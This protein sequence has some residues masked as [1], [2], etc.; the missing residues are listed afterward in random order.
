MQGEETS[1][2][3]TC[4]VGRS[5]PPTRAAAGRQPHGCER[6]PGS[7]PQWSES[8]CDHCIF[9]AA[10]GGGAC[11]HER[12][13][14]VP[15]PTARRR[16]RGGR[17]RAR[18]RQRH[19]ASGA[20]PGPATPSYRI[21]GSEWQRRSVV[22]TAERPQRPSA[23]LGG[24][25]QPPPHPSVR[26]TSMGLVPLR[27]RQF[28]PS[29]SPPAT[30]VLGTRRE[31]RQ[32]A[33]P[34]RSPPSQRRITGRGLA[35]RAFGR[36]ADQHGPQQQQRVRAGHRAAGTARRPARDAGPRAPGGHQGAPGARVE[37]WRGACW[38]M[39]G[40]RARDAEG[41]A[42]RRRCPPAARG[43]PARRSPPLRA[44]PHALAP[45]PP[46]SSPGHVRPRL[47]AG[48]PQVLRERGADAASPH[49]HHPRARGLAVL[50]GCLALLVQLL[51][52][53]LTAPP[54]LPLPPPATDRQRQGGQRAPRGFADHDHH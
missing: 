19:R 11:R 35:S 2:A 9:S 40:W 7:Q 5:C 47:P 49:P 21:V 36:H 53:V 41:A 15:P 44:H 16:G 50:A 20:R 48:H 10:G 25:R 24:A 8:A 1:S 34:C 14:N 22:V 52:L 3:R 28:P 39:W 32:P 6:A 12:P 33:Q 26:A 29:R 38:G 13:R 31:P 37:R 23:A 30:W 46:P 42:S 43:P 54:D 51:L 17:A 27:Q 45:C 18:N 4:Q